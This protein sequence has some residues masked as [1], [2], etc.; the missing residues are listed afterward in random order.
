MLCFSCVADLERRLTFELSELL[1]ETTPVGLV[2]LPL[3]LHLPTLSLLLHLRQR[4]LQASLLHSALL[5]QANMSPL[6]TVTEEPTNMV[7]KQ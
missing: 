2:E 7:P 5:L 6:N 1:I 3:L 4:L